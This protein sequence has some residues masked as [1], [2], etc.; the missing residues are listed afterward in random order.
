MIAALAP[1]DITVHFVED[2][3]T[4]HRQHGEVHCGTNS[5]R[6]I[7]QAKSIAANALVDAYV[8]FGGEVREQAAK[9]LLV[10]DDASTRSAFAQ[11]KKG[12]STDLAAALDGLDRRFAHDPAR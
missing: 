10:V 8:R 4:Y 2:W 5:T 9:A 6:Q 1:L 7:P 12:A 11:A 3:D